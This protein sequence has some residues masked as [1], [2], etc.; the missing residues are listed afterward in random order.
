[1]SDIKVEVL[2][3]AVMSNGRGAWNAQGVGGTLSIDGKKPGMYYRLPATGTKY[4]GSGID[5]TNQDQRAVKGA[6]KAYQAALNRRLGRNLTLDGVLGPVTSKAIVDWQIKAKETADGAIG[7]KT[8]KSLLLWDLAGVVSK[9]WKLYP[10]SL[11][12]SQT[13]ICGLITQESGWDAGA[14]GYVDNRDL[15]LAQIN[16]AAH[17]EYTEA[18]RLDPMVAFQFVFD[19]LRTSLDDA[20]IE[21]IDDAIASY[22]LGVGGA[23]KWIAAGRPDL[24]DP[25]GTSPDDPN[26]APRNVRKY[27]NTIKTACA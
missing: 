2:G 6:V 18:Q 1:M 24:W 27:I 3:V 16:S 17:P 11:P 8:S 15:G 10:S 22:N 23:K 25:T 7:P 4:I 12:I 21:T 9:N 13:V 20:K 14:V 26:Y 19:Y 5:T